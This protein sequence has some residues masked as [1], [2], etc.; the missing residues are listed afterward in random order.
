MYG[1]TKRSDDLH[2]YMHDGLD[3]FR[4]ELA[5]RLS[6]E[7]ARELEQAWRTAASMIGERRVII[8]L[9]GVTGIDPNARELLRRWASEGAQLAVVNHRAAARLQPITDWPLAVLTSVS[10]PRTYPLARAALWC[11]AFLTFLS[12]T[13]AATLKQDTVEAW[14]DYIQN[15]NVQIQG[16]VKPGQHFLCMDES[17]ERAARVR[18]GEVAVWTARASTPQVIPQG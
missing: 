11:A 15:A 17:G 5:G 9:S 3:T 2:F 13:N 16:R 8:D 1:S 14:E 12:P 10:V 4:F 7:S 18:R 6:A